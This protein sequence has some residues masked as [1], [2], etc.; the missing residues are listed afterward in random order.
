[1]WDFLK[2]LKEL[3]SLNYRSLFIVSGVCWIIAFLPKT[4]VEEI[5]VSV[6]W[7][8]YRPWFIAVGII[9]TSWF[10]FGVIYDL[11]DSGKNKI[12]ELR[13]RNRTQENIM[14]STSKVE[15]EILMQYLSKDTTTIAFDFRDGI[16]NGLI[17]KG[18]L[19]RASQASNPMSYKFDINIESW[20]W[21]Y[22]KKHPD[23]LRGIEP[24]TNKRHNLHF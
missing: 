6:L 10:L 11:I 13:E 21:D 9:F 24:N 7:L 12:S 17:S 2:H 18:I 14:L 5:G 20:V 3:L 15:R 16:V 19:Y 8:A 23:I 22:L 1:M 4:F